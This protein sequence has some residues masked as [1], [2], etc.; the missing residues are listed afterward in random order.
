MVLKECDPTGK[1][2]KWK[3]A[4][5]REKG[6]EHDGSRQKEAEREGKW[7]VAHQR[8]KG[9]ENDESR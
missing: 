8:E 7:K 9:A 1:E 5:P 4:H 6:A 2:W 3:W